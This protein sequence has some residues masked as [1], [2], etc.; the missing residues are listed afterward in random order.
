[1]SSTEILDRLQRE[2]TRDSEAT[3][4]S[5]ED[6]LVVAGEDG[7]HHRNATAVQI[8]TVHVVLSEH[9]NTRR[10]IAHDRANDWLQLADQQ[11]NQSRFT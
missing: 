2:V 9:G 1:M 4:V 11:V 8:E 10:V 5:S 3:E 7:H 6:L